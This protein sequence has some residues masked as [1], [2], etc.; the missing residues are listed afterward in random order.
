MSE[1]EKELCPQC[2]SALISEITGAGKRCGQ[3]GFQWGVSKNPVADA[4]AERK[5]QGVHGGWRRPPVQK[6]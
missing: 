5:R 6:T 2:G 1:N 3:C 4:V